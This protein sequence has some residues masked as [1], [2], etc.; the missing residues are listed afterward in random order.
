VKSE[1]IEL[2]QAQISMSRFQSFP[3]AILFFTAPEFAD[4]PNEL[5]LAE[6]QALSAQI[7]R[8]V[9]PI[10]ATTRSVTTIEI[11]LNTDGT[12]AAESKI[13][14]SPTPEIG[15][16]MLRAAS[17]CGPYRLPAQKYEKWKQLLVDFNL[18]PPKQN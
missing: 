10:K 6:R 15:K 3:F 11:H 12:M 18:G 2:P 7:M 16:A 9:P 5:T 13:V 14:A 8:C 1:P 4:D 17:M